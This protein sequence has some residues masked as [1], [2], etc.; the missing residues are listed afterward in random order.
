MTL[1]TGHHAQADEIRAAVASNFAGAAKEIAQRFEEKTGHKV[2][3]IFGS[4]GKHYAQ[5]TNGAPFDA[6]LAADSKRPALLERDEVAEPGTLFTYA[7]GKIALWSPRPGF[8]DPSGKTLAGGGFRR[9]ALANPKLAPYGMAAEQIL[10]KL[11]LWDTLRGEMVFGENVGQTFQFI[12]SGAAE[13]GFVALSQVRRPG[14]PAQGSFWAPPQALYD[15]IEQK[16]VLLKDNDTA[17]AFL[18][19]MKSAEALG[20]I[21]EFGY[22]A[23]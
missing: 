20:I 10:R 19:F 4:T 7:V 9:I 23:P 13:L 22:E 18:S 11:G 1:L 3:L 6:F 15:P 12:E 8:V 17:R 21:R 2:T 16:A 14:R 5:I